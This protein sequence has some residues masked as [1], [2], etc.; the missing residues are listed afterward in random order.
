[1]IKAV[2][3]ELQVRKIEAWAPL[4]PPVFYTLITWEYLANDESRYLRV[5]YM[6][7]TSQFALSCAS[8]TAIAFLGAL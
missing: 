4:K 7:L 6:S 2:P 8:S 1:M 3:A 5:I